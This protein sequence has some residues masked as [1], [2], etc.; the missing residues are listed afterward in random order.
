M[1]KSQDDR[2]STCAE[3]IDEARRAVLK[4][5]TTSARI[6]AAEPWSDASD[7]GEDAEIA[8]RA[9]TIAPAAETSAPAPV[10]ASLAADE[11]AAAGGG[12]YAGPPPGA[13]RAARPRW[14]AFG[15]IA[16]VAAALSGVV[17]YFVADNGSS[18][19]SA[20][21]TSTAPG[22]AT[23]GAGTVTTGAGTTTSGAPVVATGLTGVVQDPVWPHCKPSASALRGA[24]ASAVCVPIASDSGFFP[25]RLEL[26]LYSSGAALKKAFNAVRASD[27]KSAALVEGRGTCNN[28]TWSGFGP[29]HHAN[30]D[31][32]GRRYC[33]F[34]AKHQAVVVWTHERL[35]TPSHLDFMAIASDSSRGDN[36]LF[37]WWNFWHQHLG[38]CFASANCVAHVT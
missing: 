33:F 30:G 25:Q 29:W 17:V 9:E 31:L 32:G 11:A 10:A 36:R 2:Y 22:T 13:A 28:V 37:S 14:L 20:S 35:G 8:P 21:S 24:A 19:P 6:P 3:L 16:L 1:A 18:S 23:T 5:T 7:M 38:K 4:R 27:P 26:Y 34:D 12:S 15:L